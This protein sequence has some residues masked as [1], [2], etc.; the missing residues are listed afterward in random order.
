[1]STARRYG[2]PDDVKALVAADGVNRPAGTAAQLDDTVLWAR[3]ETA[4]AQVDAALAAASR[5]VP[6]DPDTDGVIVGAPVLVRDVALAIA[7]Y[8][9]DLT[10]RETRQHDE[11]SPNRARY[12]WAQ[13]QLEAWA[14]GR[15][16]PAGTDVVADPDTGDI[17]I[18][19]PINPCVPILFGPDML[20][21]GYRTTGWWGDVYDPD[22]YR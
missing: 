19:D 2:R 1:M 4:T 13:Q 11:D 21:P 22:W 14:T 20:D 7:A 3:I 8:L 18:G 12:L 16:L 17:T 9:A 15:G 6:G 10:Y 5:K